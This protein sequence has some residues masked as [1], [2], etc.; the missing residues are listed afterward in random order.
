MLCV[1]YPKMTHLTGVALVFHPVA[2]VVRGSY[3]KVDLL[4]SSVKKV[5]LKA[6]KRVHLLKEMY[7]E[8]PL[9]PK[10]VLTRWGTWLQ[11]VEYYAEYIDSIK[12]VL[13]AM[14][15]EDAAS[16]EAAQ[17]VVCDTSVRNDYLHSA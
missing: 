2:E 7:P 14:D 5:F 17:T 8:I 12:N 16:I 9:P 10:P 15:S 13:H 11:A 4:I 3:P 1:V 6:H